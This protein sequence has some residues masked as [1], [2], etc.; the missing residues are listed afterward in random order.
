M[1]P[2]PHACER[3]ALALSG[4]EYPLRYYD[5]FREYS[6]LVID[7][8]E[9]VL[10][11]EYCPFCG[12]KLPRSVRDDWYDRLDR[13]GLDPDSDAIPDMMKSGSWWRSDRL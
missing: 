9:S 5:R 3:M 1:T 8:G 12:V 11:I 6:V 13:L 4:T 7:G 10:I 2:A